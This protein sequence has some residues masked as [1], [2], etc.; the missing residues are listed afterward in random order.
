ML[1]T[2]LREDGFNR[3]RRTAVQL[4]PVGLGDSGVRH[5]A[6]LVVDETETRRSLLQDLPAQELADC[7]H[8]RLVGQLCH[9]VQQQGRDVAALQALLG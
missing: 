7:A 5:F 2:L 1:A 4:G 6:N 3:Q 9:R 8:P